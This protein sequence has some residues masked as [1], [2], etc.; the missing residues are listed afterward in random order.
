MSIN[1]IIITILAFCLSHSIFAANEK[2][3]FAAAPTHSAAETTKLYTPIINFLSAKTGKKFTLE[4]PATFIEYSNRMQAGNYDMV[5]D[6]PHL[7]GWRMDRQQHTPI[8][9]LPGK[10]KIVIAVNSDSPLSKMD[11]IQY[12]AKVCSFTP[13]NLL[14]MA[15][16]S[17]FTNP[18]KQPDLIRV[19]E[20]KNL[21]QCL[22]SGKGDAAVL[23]DKL[24]VKAQKSGAAKGLKIIAQPE[25]SYPERTFTAGPKIDANLRAQIT[26][27][28]LSKEGQKA[29]S[30]L[31]KKFK[32][33]QLVQASP[34]EYVGLSYLIRTVWGFE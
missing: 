6:G 11:D 7:S 23:R 5:F 18:S 31:L 2:L 17:Y 26:Q 25:R 20:L 30:L 24:W 9:K 13:P 12:G 33:K 3:I 15:M 22:K 29:A 1:R 21:I 34:Q 4:I 32:K 19:N 10:I 8:I 27:L 28:L 16:L 14:T